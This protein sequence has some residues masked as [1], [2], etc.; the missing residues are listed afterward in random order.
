M[1]FGLQREERI[2]PLLRYPKFPVHSEEYYYSLFASLVP[3]HSED[4]ILCSYETAEDAFVNKRHLLDTAI[5]FKDFSFTDDVDNDIKRINCFR[6]EMRHQEL[7]QW[8]RC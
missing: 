8:C 3:H 6:D 7:K 4:E 1:T 2:T 5:D